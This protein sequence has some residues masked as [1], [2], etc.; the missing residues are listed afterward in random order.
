MFCKALELYEH[1]KLAY[2]SKSLEASSARQVAERLLQGALENQIS[3]DGPRGC[4]DVISS[5]ACGAEAESIREAQ[6]HQRHRI[7]RIRLTVPKQPERVR[8]IE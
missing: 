7:R 6:P 2:V 5:V 1:E 4:L 3:N 8:D